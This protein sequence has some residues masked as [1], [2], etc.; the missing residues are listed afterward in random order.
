MNQKI[1]ADFRPVSFLAVFLYLTYTKVQT[2]P[3]NRRTSKVEGINGE[4]ESSVDFDNLSVD[5]LNA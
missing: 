3:T 2:G 5:R 4:S 1:S